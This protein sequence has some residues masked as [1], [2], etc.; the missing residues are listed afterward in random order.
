MYKFVSF[1]DK[2]EFE[3]FLIA[4]NIVN[5]YATIVF[6]NDRISCNVMNKEED[7]MFSGIV[8]HYRTSIAPEV[9]FKVGLYLDQMIR[10]FATMSP[11]EVGLLLTSDMFIVDNS[12]TKYMYSLYGL[13]EIDLPK[14]DYPVIMDISSKYLEYIMTNLHDSPSIIFSREEDNLLIASADWEHFVTVCKKDIAYDKDLKGSYS[15]MV[16]TPYMLKALEVLSLFDSVRIGLGEDIPIVFL[17][18]SPS[19][20]LGFMIGAQVEEESDSN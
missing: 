3:T 5:P 16:S 19:L 11:G 20:K 9:T 8:S 6:G 4:I 10:D 14:F 18:T 1:V 13:Y 17:G 2:D 7:M 15:T 12:I